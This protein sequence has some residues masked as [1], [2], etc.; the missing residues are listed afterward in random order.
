MQAPQLEDYTKWSENAL[1]S[2][3]ELQE[4]TAKTVEKLMSQQMSLVNTYF[5]VTTKQMTAMS[6]AKGY[7][8][9]MNMQAAAMNAYSTAVM[10]NIKRASE[11]MNESK[12][13]YGEWLNKAMSQ[14]G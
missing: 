2:M 13:Q 10:E 7:D 4:I 11:L 1:S 6:E 5:D 14:K 3:K 9:V 8:E 12:D